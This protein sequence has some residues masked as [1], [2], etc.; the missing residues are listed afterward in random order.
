MILVEFSVFERYHQ[1]VSRDFD[2]L[3]E[4]GGRNVPS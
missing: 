4:T 1:F 3:A 2:L